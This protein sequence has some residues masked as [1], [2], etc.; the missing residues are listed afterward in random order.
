M[1]PSKC[2][3]R[4]SQC[5]WTI[6]K[7][8]AP[9]PRHA[10]LYLRWTPVALVLWMN[11]ATPTTSEN[12]K[13]TRICRVD[14]SLVSESWTKHSF[15]LWCESLQNDQ[16]EY[17]L[18]FLTKIKDLDVE[19]KFFG[20]EPTLYAQERSID[21][22]YAAYWAQQWMCSI[23]KRGV[24][25]LTP[26]LTPFTTRRCCPIVER[27]TSVFLLPQRRTPSLG[28]ELRASK[29]DPWAYSLFVAI[30]FMK[31]DRLILLYRFNMENPTPVELSNVSKHVFRVS[32]STKKAI[33]SPNCQTWA[34]VWLSIFEA[35]LWY[36]KYA[37]P[38]YALGVLSNFFTCQ[39]R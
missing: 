26:L 1:R 29:Q 7:F 6:F 11:A 35:P 30:D 38:M 22:T 37:V 21:D 5:L 27:G 8:N 16:V 24:R 9:T 28:A 36:V 18:R 15:N 2:E 19:T 31:S 14:G 10:R 39:I 33:Y 20:W 17:Y 4:S 23:V 13:Q 3:T 25:V 34:S 32:T 12:C